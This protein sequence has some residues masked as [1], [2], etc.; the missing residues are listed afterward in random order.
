MLAAIQHW[1]TIGHGKQEIAL[2]K[3]QWVKGLSLCLSTGVGTP[4]THIR[5]ESVI[6]AHRGADRESPEPAGLLD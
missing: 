4:R 6:P 3:A 5:A 1:I 2:E